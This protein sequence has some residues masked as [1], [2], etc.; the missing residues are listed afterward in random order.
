VQ[1]FLKECGTHRFICSTIINCELETELELACE[2]FRMAIAF[3]M[4]GNTHC[5]NALLEEM[6]TSENNRVLRKLNDLIVFV[7]RKIID[8][9]KV[10]KTETVADETFRIV[11]NDTYDFFD[12]RENR[13][14]RKNVYEPDTDK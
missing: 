13:M 14:I 8:Y 2:L 10:S 5:Q 1:Y 11:T 6:Q 9:F 4:D 12:L 3:L 7:S